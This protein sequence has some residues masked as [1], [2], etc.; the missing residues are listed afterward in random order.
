MESENQGGS[1]LTGVYLG[2]VIIMV[3]MFAIQL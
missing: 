2:M 3:C 1:W